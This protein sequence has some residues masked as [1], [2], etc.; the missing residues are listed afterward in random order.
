MLLRG[1]LHDVEYLLF[2][3]IP[4]PRACIHFILP[5]L[6]PLVPHPEERLESLLDPPEKLVLAH[7][8]FPNLLLP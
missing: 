1:L 5:E 4:L 6:D 8:D 2:G 7:E 3:S